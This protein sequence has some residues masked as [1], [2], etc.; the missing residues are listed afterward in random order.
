MNIAGLC[1]MT[2]HDLGDRMNAVDVKEMIGRDVIILTNIVKIPNPRVKS[3][4][5]SVTGPVLGIVDPGIDP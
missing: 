3:V 5:R 4:H 2:G 1:E